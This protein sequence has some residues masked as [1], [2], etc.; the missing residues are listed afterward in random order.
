LSSSSVEHR[1]GLVVRTALSGAAGSSATA[2]SLI[3]AELGDTPQVT[4]STDGYGGRGGRHRRVDPNVVV[5]L[6]FAGGGE[7]A[8]GV[9][10]PVGRSIAHLAAL[11]AER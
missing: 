2:R 3:D 7:V 9:D 6:V 8:L 10:H 5:H 11:L 4:A 1:Y